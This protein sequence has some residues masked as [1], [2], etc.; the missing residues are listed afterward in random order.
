MKKVIQLIAFIGIM[1][2]TGHTAKASHLLGGEITWECTANGKYIFTLAIYKECGGSTAGL[3]S[4]QNLSGPNGSIQLS[5]ISVTEVSPTC[6]GGGSISCATSGPGNGAVER[7][8]YTNDGVAGR[9]QPTTLSGVPGAGGWVFSWYSCCRPAGIANITSPTSAGYFLRAVMYPYTPA[10]A[11][12]PLNA[13]PCYDNSPK[14]NE[15]GSLTICAGSPFT[16]NHLASDK[17]LDSLFIRFGDAK[18]NSAGTQNVNWVSNY[19]RTSPYP[20]NLTNAGNGPITLDGRTGEVSM[21]IQTA[22]QGSYVSCYEVEA[23]KCGVDANGNS[24]MIKVASVFRDVAIVVI[25]NC[26]NN[27]E[28]NAFIDTSTYKNI[29]QLGPKTYKTSVYPGDTVN[30]RLSATDTDINPSTFLPQQITFQAA[31]L[32]VSRPMASGTGC[33]GVAPC[34]QF[35]PV[36]PQ[37]GYVKALNNNIEFFWVPDCQHLNVEGSYCNPI[38]TFFFSMRMQDDGCPAPEIALTTFIVDVLPGDPS[39]L[40][41]T[42]LNVDSVSGDRKLGW[43]K[44]TID[45]ALDFNYYMVLAGPNSTGG[46]DTIQKIYDIDSLGTIVSGSGGYNNFYIIK[47]TGKCD[48]L[49][50]PSDTLTVM[51]LTMN[52]IVTPLGDYADL[53]WTKL[54]DPLPYTSEGL[55]QVWQEVPAGSGNWKQVGQTNGTTYVDTVQVCDLFVNYQ[56][57]VA[58]TTL[59]Y[60]GSGSNLQKGR[61][62]DKSNDDPLQLDSVSVNANGNSIIS[63]NDTKNGDVV[64]YYL[65]FNDPKLGWQIVDTIPEGTP[66]PHEWT[67]SEADTR[68]E[69]FRII[70]ADSC[71]NFSD[72]QLVKPH[73]TI[74][75]RNYLNKCEAYSRLSWNTYEGFGNQGVAEYRIWIQEI[76]NGTPGG[77]NILDTRTGEDTTYTQYNLQNGYEYCYRIQVIDTSGAKSS[78]SNELCILAEVPSKSKIL[79][80]AQVTNNTNRNT[81]ELNTYIDAQADVLNFDIERALTPEGPFERIA[82]IPKPT[83]GNTFNFFDYGANPKSNIYYYR[84]SATDSCGGRDTVTDLS[85]NVLLNVEARGDVSNMLSWNTYKNWAGDVAR[86][87]VYRQAEDETSYSLIAQVSSADSTYQDNFDRAVYG[88]GEG[89]FCYYVVAVEGP[90]PLV[91]V[92][93][94]GDPYDSRSN[95][96]CMNQK[97]RVFIPTAFNPNS[98]QEINR[99]FGPSMK[100]TEVSQYSF[101]IMNRWGVKVFETTNPEERW[102]GTFDGT[103]AAQG[104]YIYF[105]TY[106]TP[107][108][109]ATEER[110]S[111][112]LIR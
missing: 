81:M 14:F 71:G 15:T 63:W 8:V 41:L 29:K 73:A 28:P 67:N 92:Q 93:P 9:P 62:S 74:Y 36:A 5:Q 39:P 52:V 84:V 59:L 33:D 90:N 108:E 21:D 56:V 12:A 42:C 49:S 30:F 64:V 72:N 38:N 35:T 69:E 96:V 99:S 48:F 34:A 44:A 19:S 45:S 55:Y 57:R 22:T 23:W 10:G 18:I 100:F 103:E 37:V 65:F 53:S 86:Y 20:S 6:L 13:N 1:L 77:W 87:D 79:Y 51:D 60:C 58:D 70:S 97:A 27:N 109:V 85:N 80:V 54:S 101:Y 94:N 7:Y 16:Y 3:G 43:E 95:T 46:Y 75:L 47:S 66:M 26:V 89:N 88:E 82:T 105:I 112:T 102:D 106:A 76:V 25:N 83:V 61:F 98:E 17:D 104:V 40:N 4:T 11:T 50:L 2:F 110:G 24:K 32:E 111:F 68:S 31:G 78:T 107:G 91:L